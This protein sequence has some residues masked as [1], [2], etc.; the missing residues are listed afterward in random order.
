[1]AI[2]SNYLGINRSTS[3]TRGNSIAYAA[4]QDIVY[5]DFGNLQKKY[6][7]SIKNI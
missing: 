6:I 7:L 1:M 2:D 5:Y 4:S 3:P